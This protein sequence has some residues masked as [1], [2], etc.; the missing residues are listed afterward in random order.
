V[1]VELDWG[2]LPVLLG[3]DHSLAIGSISAVARH[4]RAAVAQALAQLDAN[5]HLHL[6][7]DVD[8]LTP[9]FAPGVSAP[10]PGGL[11]LEE[12]Q[13]CLTMIGHTGRL[14]SL[15]VME[16]NPAEDSTHTTAAVTAGL[17]ATLFGQGCLA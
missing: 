10:V 16:L 15:D 8:V 17:I 6:S 5:T 2:R 11:S 1:Q 13:L 7:F 14:A 9:D 12:A 4:C 3:G